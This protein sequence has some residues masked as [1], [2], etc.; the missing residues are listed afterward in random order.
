MSFPKYVTYI[1]NV[2]DYNNDKTFLI[3]NQTK[4]KS[5]RTYGFQKRIRDSNSHFQV[6]QHLCQLRPC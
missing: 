5:N 6:L 3:L 1:T 4:E 2:Y